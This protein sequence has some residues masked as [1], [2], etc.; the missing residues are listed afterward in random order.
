MLARLPKLGEVLVAMVRERTP[1]REEDPQ[2]GLLRDSMTFEVDREAGVVRIGTPLEIGRYIE[3]GTERMAPRAP[4]RKALA[5]AV[6]NDVIP[7][8]LSED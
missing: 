1:V 2:P 8:V 4:I 7:K 3:L 6:S 5:D